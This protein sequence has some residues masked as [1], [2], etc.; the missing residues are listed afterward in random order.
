MQLYKRRHSNYPFKKRVGK[1]FETIA[2]CGIILLLATL[3]TVIPTTVWYFVFFKPQLDIGAASEG[4]STAAWVPWLA[5]VC[6]WINNTVLTKVLDE[7]KEMRAANKGY[8]IETFMRLRD[9]DVSPLIYA[10]IIVFD[11]ATIGGF[12]LIHYADFW[13]GFFFVWTSAYMASLFL[14]VIY[15]LDDPLAGVWFIKNVHQEWT[16]IDVKKWR[17]EYYT[18]RRELC[19]KDGLYFGLYKCPE[20]KVVVALHTAEL[21]PAEEVGKKVA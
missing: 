1:F 15:E 12:M 2:K 9:E 14:L 21:T 13:H 18:K 11:L 10:L 5:I 6:G 4:I 16:D 19:Q 3:C 17:V 8:D 20:E 7:Y